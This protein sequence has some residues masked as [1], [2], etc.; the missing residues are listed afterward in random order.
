[1]ITSASV[2]GVPSKN[3]FGRLNYYK[4]NIIRNEFNFNLQNHH[5]L[6]A[7]ILCCVYKHFANKYK[8]L[9]RNRQLNEIADML[10][11]L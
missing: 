6:R 5:D 1:M 4:F 2:Y 3:N 11:K 9:S 7:L 8:P 10:T